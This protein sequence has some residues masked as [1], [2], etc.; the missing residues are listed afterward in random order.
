LDSV[1]LCQLQVIRRDQALAAGISMAKLDSLVARGRWR[2]MLP[3]VYSVGADCA[4]T[5]VRIRAGWL[6]AGDDATVAGSAAAWW[7][8]LTEVQ[9]ATIEIIVPTARR[10][11]AQPG[12]SVAR[13]GL[14]EEQSVIVDRIAV[15]SCARTCLDLAR[16]GR[17][18]LLDNALRLRKVTQSQLDASVELSRG[19]R[20]QLRARA[21]RVAVKDNPWS[22]PERAAHRLFREAGLTGWTANQPV[23]VKDG[24]RFPD[25]LFEEIKLMVEIDGRAHHGTREANEADFRR[26]NQ[27]VRAGWTVLRFT[28]TELAN[29]PDDVVAAVRETIA[30]L[31][32]NRAKT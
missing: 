27:F 25:I 16:S 22:S 1:L 4:A 17:P 14:P 32:A 24:R 26:Q 6:W 20:G 13:A 11:S 8:G 7:H 18:D 30:Y 29:D 21:A 10:M 31:R 28:P 2:K 12:Y 19:A 15:T 23:R 9:P 5:A 3:R